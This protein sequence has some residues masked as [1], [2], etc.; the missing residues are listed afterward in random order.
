MENEKICPLKEDCPYNHN[1]R[2]VLTDEELNNIREQLLE[3]I[4]TDIGKSI[5]HKILWVFGAIVL[6]TF[7]WLKLEGKA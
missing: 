2:K 1:R 3:S 4:Y 7:T 6:A 5:T